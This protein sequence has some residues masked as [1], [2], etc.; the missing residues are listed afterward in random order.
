MKTGTPVRADGRITGFYKNAGAKRRYNTGTFFLFTATSE[1]TCQ[2]SCFLTYTNGKVH[3]ILRTG[4]EKSPLFTGRIKGKGPRYCPSIE[5]KIERFS[6]KE[7]HQFFIEP[8]GWNTVEYYV[9][10]FSSSLPEDIQ[11]EALRKIPG[12]ENAEIFQTRICNRI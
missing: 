6:T 8:E 2:K 4:F 10:G 12:F 11:F 9:N 5:D 7:R 3:D 1:L